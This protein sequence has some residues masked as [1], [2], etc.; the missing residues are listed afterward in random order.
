[1]V[2]WWLVS[3]EVDFSEI[4]WGLIL[5]PKLIIHFCRG[6]LMTNFCK[7]LHYKML[8]F[9]A[10]IYLELMSDPELSSVLSSSLLL[11][12]SMTFVSLL[13]RSP[14]LDWPDLVTS[15]SRRR[16]QVSSWPRLRSRSARR[17]LVAPAGD[18][19]P[20]DLTRTASIIR[21]CKRGYKNESAN[22]GMSAWA[23]NHY[24][25]K[26]LKELAVC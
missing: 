6:K 19:S 23:V 5:P 8:N 13:L 25:D 7:G 9:E 26:R 18:S 11:L 24:W 22:E 15:S 16:G 12:V 4:N 17:R 1:M 10:D 14:R 20:P 2:N 21:V 3:A